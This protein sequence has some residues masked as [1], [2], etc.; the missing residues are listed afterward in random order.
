VYVGANWVGILGGGMYSLSP[1]VWTYSVQVCVCVWCVCVCGACVCACVGE[2]VRVCVYKH[3]YIY[4]CVCW[5]KLGGHAQRRYVL[6]PATRV[7]V[8]RAVVCLGGEGKGG[9]G[10]CGGGGVFGGGGGGGVVCDDKNEA[11][12]SSMS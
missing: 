10:G 4:G 3:M 7:H 1:L 6:P 8:F 12:L 9:G 2:C 5:R 11:R